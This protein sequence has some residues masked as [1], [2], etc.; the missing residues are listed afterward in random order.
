MFYNF[1]HIRLIIKTLAML[2]MFYTITRLFFF[3]YNFQSF[4]NSNFTDIL[5]AFTHGIRFDMVAIVYLNIL[6]VLLYI[7]ILFK[8]SNKAY[9]KFCEW[10]FYIL[11]FAGF[12]FNNIDA[13]YYR[14]QKRRT[15]IDLFN[16]ENDNLTLLPSYLAEYWWIIV[17]TLFIMFFVRKMYKSIH[18]I[19]VVE[20]KNHYALK[21][22][23]FILFLSLLVII[24]RGGLQ[25]KPIQI[26]TASYYGNA[27][28]ASLVLNTPFTILQ[29]LG[30]EKLSYKNYFDEKSLE[31]EFNL[32]RN[33]KSEKVFNPKN[34][35]IIILES[36]SNEY[37]GAINK[38]CTTSPFLDSLI[39]HSYLYWNGFSNGKKSNEAMPS[40]ISS[41]PSIMDETYTGSFYQDNDLNSLPL[42]LKKKGYHSSFFHGG[43]NGSMSFDVFAKKAGYDHYYGMNEYPSTKDYDGF[44]GIYDEPFFRFFAEKLGS[45]PKPFFATIF[46]LSSHPP[47]AVPQQFIDNH[48][49]VKDPKLRS[50]LYTDNALRGFFN[51]V[52][53]KM[54]FSNTLFVIVPDHTPDTQNKYYDTKVSYYKIPIIF[55]DPISSWNGSSGLIAEHLDIMPTVLDYLN[56]DK[57]FKSFGTSLLRKDSKKSYTVNYRDGI[58]QCIDSTHVLQYSNDQVVGF[59]N[60]VNDWYLT[61]NLKDQESPKKD[62]MQ[63]YLKAFIQK[64]N[65]TLIDN[66]YKIEN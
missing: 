61:N 30:K 47:F 43:F 27:Q 5:I 13:E 50:F 63:N 31:K 39:Q 49:D 59:Y 18:R 17:I 36:Y 26:I 57:P 28:N 2:L 48:K 7:P 29:S 34:V 22:I 45:S 24:A 51:Y 1:K 42:L 20:C 9:E 15:N 38:E 23:S 54:W 35:V 56:Y 8:I 46:S 41:I 66:Q 6:W 16:G 19:P 65:V 4:S 12:L 55:Y 52:K 14:Y 10:A 3:A 62:S 37:I 58:Y 25:T 32:N 21:T 64:F 53:N 60:Y 44:W 33:Y 11:N 40:I